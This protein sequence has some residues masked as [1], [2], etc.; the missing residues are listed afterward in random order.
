MS[1]AGDQRGNFRRMCPAQRVLIDSKAPSQRI[2]RVR[3][4]YELVQHFRD[5]MWGDSLAGTGAWSDANGVASNEYPHKK[6]QEAVVHGSCR[7]GS[8]VMNL[9]GCQQ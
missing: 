5:R 7:I 3:N 4:V 2:Q 8:E 1:S 9:I 6:S